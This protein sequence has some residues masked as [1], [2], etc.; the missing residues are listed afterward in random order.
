MEFPGQGSDPSHSCNLCCGCSNTRSLT[1]WSGPGSNLHSGAAWMLSIQ[2]CY[3]G[4]SWVPS[5]NQ[6]FF[7]SHI[8]LFRVKSYM[9]KVFKNYKRMFLDKEWGNASDDNF[10]LITCSVPFS[11]YYQVVSFFSEGKAH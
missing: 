10:P 6:C 9:R 11:D 5:F 2:L 4:N 7:V 1:H 3:I 8:L